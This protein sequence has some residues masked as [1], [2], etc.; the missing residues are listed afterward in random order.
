M[1]QLS[2]TPHFAQHLPG[3][4]VEGVLYFPPVSGSVDPTLAFGRLVCL[5]NY[6]CITPPQ[7][8][9]PISSTFHTGEIRETNLRPAQFSPKVPPG[10]ILQFLTAAA[11]GDDENYTVLSARNHELL[12]IAH[13]AD[14]NL[15]KVYTALT[16]PK[17]PESWVGC[18][19]LVKKSS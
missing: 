5:P 18:T 12:Q 2:H 10:A 15:A 6:D 4:G 19:I 1:P 13:T 17:Y 9:W 8:R 16:G 7:H 3:Y 11:L 14:R